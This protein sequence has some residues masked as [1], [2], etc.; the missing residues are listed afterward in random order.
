V[1]CLKAARKHIRTQAAHLVHGLPLQASISIQLSL[2][3]PHGERAGIH[4][5]CLG[6]EGLRGSREGKG[7]TQ[8]KRDL[9]VMQAAAGHIRVTA[10]EVLRIVVSPHPPV[11]VV[12][13]QGRQPGPSNRA[14]NKVSIRIRRV[15]ISMRA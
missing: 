1:C 10:A 7:R 11:E 15:S 14:N 2:R 8:G 12:S 9:H 4:G 5:V 13:I 3:R 6:G